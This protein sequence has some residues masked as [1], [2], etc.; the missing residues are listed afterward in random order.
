MHSSLK[1][2]GLQ[3]VSCCLVRIKVLV[4]SIFDNMLTVNDVKE[5]NCPDAKV[6]DAIIH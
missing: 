2:R 3:P 5:K 6:A 4:W 1:F